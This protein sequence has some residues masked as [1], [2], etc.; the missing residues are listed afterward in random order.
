MDAQGPLKGVKVLD[1]TRYQNGP[2]ATC[3]LSDFGADVVK[4]EHTMGGDPGRANRMADGYQFYHEAFNRGKRSLTLDLTKPE[5]QGV[6]KKLVEWADVLT[7][8]FR[9]GYLERLGFGYEKMKQINP[10]LIYASNSGFGPR[11]AWAHRGSFDAICQAFSGMS[12]AQ[13]GGKDFKP[14]LA[15]NCIADQVGAMNFAYSIVS[16]LYAREKTGTGQKLETSQL[17]ACVGLQA[18]WM[19]ASMH[20]GDQRNDGKVPFD[21]SLSLMFCKAQDGWFSIAPAGDKFWPRVC[22]AAERPDLITDPRSKDFSVRTK[23]A[24]W[25]NAEL[26]KSWIA[27]PR[28]YWLD[29]FE[30]ADVPCGPCLDYDGVKNNQQIWDNGYLTKLDHPRFGEQTYVGVPSLFSGTPGKVQ[31]VAPEF[32]EHNTDV[33]SNVAGL[34]AADIEKLVQAKAVLPQPA[35]PPKKASKL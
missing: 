1:L 6:M 2:W 5:A 30:R 19:T 12:V 18:F 7:E 13:A 17:G 25:I 3:M 10:K 34:S 35:T 21:G 27:K 33:L 31:G 22:Q 14:I 23:N 24:A 11:G 15:E 26:D 28:E 9:P 16:A 29:A 20:S 8:N 32:G 4:V